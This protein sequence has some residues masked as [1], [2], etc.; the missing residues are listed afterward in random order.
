MAADAA[1]SIL[2]RAGEYPLITVMADCHVV[3]V[4]WNGGPLL[5]EA[6]RSLARQTVKPVVWVVDNA[7]TDGSAL[8]AKQAFPEINLL[9]QATNLGF[10]EGNNVA[11][12]QLPETKYVLLLNNDAWFPQED[13]LAKVLAFM[14]ANPQIQGACGRFEYPDGEFQRFYH[15]LPS[16]ANLVVQYGCG[17]FIKAWRTGAAMNRF[18]MIGDDYSRPMEIEQPA[19]ACVLMR[20]GAFRRTGLL[21]KEFPI[22]FNDVDYCWRWRQH[23]F[24][25]HY[26]PDWRIVHHH[27]KSVKKM[28]TRSTAEMRGSAVRFARKH[29]P[30]GAGLILGASIFLDMTWSNW[31]HKQH[32]FSPWQMA[33][34]NHFFL[35]KP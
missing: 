18:L 13:A 28:A 12:R 30:A 31:R 19:F 16:L 7:S 23:G 11:L 27:G 9:P 21:D 14:D 26:L 20:N 4:N 6:V 25:W 35:P 10:A 15:R 33:R 3:I 32:E 22:F 29:L 5:M 1:E 17:R 2:Q 24:T 8:E 34:G